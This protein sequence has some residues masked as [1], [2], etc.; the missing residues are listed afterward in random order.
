MI[1]RGEHETRYRF[2][3]P[4]FLE[5][6][7]VRLTPLCNAAQELLLFEVEVSPLPAWRCDLIEASGNPAV[8]LWVGQTCSSG[9]RNSCRAIGVPP[10]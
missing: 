4:V 5:P 7:L 2:S 3:R 1:F 10:P 9:Y 6:H 8:R